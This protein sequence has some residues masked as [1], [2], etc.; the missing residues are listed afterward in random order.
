[1]K[2]KCQILMFRKKKFVKLH[3]SEINPTTV[4]SEHQLSMKVNIISLERFIWNRM[5]LL[6]H[7]LVRLIVSKFA[8]QIINSFDSSTLC[9]VN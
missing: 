2:E 8:E 1:M 4:H 5:S 9:F 3:N 7:L 6:F